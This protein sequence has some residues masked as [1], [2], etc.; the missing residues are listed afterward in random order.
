MRPSADSV[1]S[2]AAIPRSVRNSMSRPL[3][4]QAIV[5]FAFKTEQSA[6]DFSVFS[7]ANSQIREYKFPDK[8]R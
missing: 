4:E 7:F 3:P 2:Y 5:S 1:P 8:P 6:N